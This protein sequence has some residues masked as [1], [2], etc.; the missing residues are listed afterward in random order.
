MDILDSLAI[1]SFEIVSQ[2]C[3]WQEQKRNPPKIKNVDYEKNGFQSR[4]TLS[5]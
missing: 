3:S 4:D 1:I 2:Q 5:L